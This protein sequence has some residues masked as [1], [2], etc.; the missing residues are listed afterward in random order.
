MKPSDNANNMEAQKIK[1]L[2]LIHL[3][4]CAGVIVFCAMTDTLSLSVFEIPNIASEAYIYVAIPFIAIIASNLLF[5][6]QIKKVSKNAPLEDKFEVY[7]TASIIRWAILEGASFFVLVVKPELAIL[8]ILV[9]LY[10][11]TLRPT[12][13]KINKELS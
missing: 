1:T 8:G 12:E 7:K 2:Q 13:D 6:M 9:L 10:L 4:I 3:A 5:Q 11:I